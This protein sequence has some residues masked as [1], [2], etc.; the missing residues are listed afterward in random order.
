MFSRKISFGRVKN[1]LAS[2]RW[3]EGAH[4]LV[5]SPLLTRL[6]RYFFAVAMY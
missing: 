2:V 6:D 3:K 5:T 1:F 4:S